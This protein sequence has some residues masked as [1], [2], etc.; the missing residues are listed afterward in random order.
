MSIYIADYLVIHS[1]K[2]LLNFEKQRVRILTLI[3]QF[4]TSAFQ[5]I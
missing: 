3:I 2:G 5:Y 1:A 4:V